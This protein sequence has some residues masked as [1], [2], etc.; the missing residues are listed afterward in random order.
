M[1][2]QQTPDAQ[3]VDISESLLARDAIE[4][5]QGVST[6]TVERNATQRVDELRQ[7]MA[8]KLAGVV[9]TVRGPADGGRLD[10]VR[11][12]ASSLISTA[13]DRLQNLHTPDLSAINMQQ[14][15]GQAADIVRRYPL[16]SLAVGL[17][18]GLLF[19]RAV[20]RR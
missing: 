15:R 9:D 10:P 18:I 8:E 12:R 4:P 6:R 7:K 13:A 17:G 11:E 16:Q 20:T 14:M 5:Q 3:G 2:T 1:T 19:G